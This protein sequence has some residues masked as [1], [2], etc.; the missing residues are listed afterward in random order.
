MNTLSINEFKTQIGG[1]FCDLDMDLD[2]DFEFKN[3]ILATS[4]KID[5]IKQS[6]DLGDVSV[7]NLLDLLLAD[8]IHIMVIILIA[9]FLIPVS[10]PGSSTPFGILIILLELSVLFN[11]QLILPKMV[12]EYTLSEDSMDKLFE[13]AILK[14][15]ELNREK[16]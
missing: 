10:I 14:F 7:K 15:F 8:G 12:S 2:Y 5:I 11:R 3:S 4:K 16:L 9:P 13:V 1:K 6:V